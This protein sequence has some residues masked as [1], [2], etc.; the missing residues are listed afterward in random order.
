VCIHTNANATQ[1]RCGNTY[2]N[3]NGAWERVVLH[4]D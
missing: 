4:A 2:L 3:D 1:N